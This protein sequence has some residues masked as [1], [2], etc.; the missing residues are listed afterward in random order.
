MPKRVRQNINRPNKP[1]S[2]EKSPATGSSSQAALLGR[3]PRRSFECRC[4]LCQGYATDDSDE[5]DLDDAGDDPGESD[6]DDV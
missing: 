3:S 5:P 6:A 2:Y 1:F 4:D